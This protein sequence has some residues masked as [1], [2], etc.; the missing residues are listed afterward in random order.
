MP[1]RP[2]TI[3]LE[4]QRVKVYRNLQNGLFSV[5]FRGRVVAHLATV[6][7]VAV[8]FKVTET[9]RQRVLTCRQKNVHAYAIGTF[10]QVA[11]PAATEPISYDPYRAG[12]FYQVH[13][14]QPLL[15]ALAVV[16]HQGKA[17]AQLSYPLTS[18][19]DESASLLPENTRAQRLVT[20]PEARQTIERRAR[21]GR[22]HLDWL[23]YRGQDGVMRGELATVYAYKR[24]LLAIGTKGR[25][26]LH[27]GSGN[28]QLSW[29]T[30]LNTLYQLAG[31]NTA[32]PKNG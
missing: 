27:T 25:F 17:F 32:V 5:Q 2:L 4:G 14:E 21:Y 22:D 8:T 28:L 16:L 15:S 30:G 1:P 24:A 3:D 11:Q 23:S 6:Q 10:T 7:L 13:N 29:K 18:T 31:W 12:H 19:A 26:K 9:G 20:G